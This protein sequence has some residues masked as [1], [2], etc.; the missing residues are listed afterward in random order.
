MWIGSAQN[1]AVPSRGRIHNT[2]RSTEKL[3]LLRR[4]CPDLYND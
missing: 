1:D 2:A 4:E 3:V